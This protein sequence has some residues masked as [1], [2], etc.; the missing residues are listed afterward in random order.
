M[1]VGGCLKYQASLRL[2]SAKLR[3]TLWVLID[4]TAKPSPQNFSAIFTPIILKH[5]E[6]TATMLR[7][8]YVPETWQSCIILLTRYFKQGKE[9]AHCAHP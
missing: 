7:E 4:K 1:L 6:R 8:V 2:Q 5:K 3:P 9:P